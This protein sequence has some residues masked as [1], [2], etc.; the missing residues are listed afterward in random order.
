MDKGIADEIVKDCS[1][2]VI[3]EGAEFLRGNYLKWYSNKHISKVRFD[4][5]H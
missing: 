5:L 3:L 1:G 4:I 2:H